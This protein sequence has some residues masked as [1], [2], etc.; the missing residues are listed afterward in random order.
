MQELFGIIEEESKKA[1]AESLEHKQKLWEEELRRGQG[2][3]HGKKKQQTSHPSTSSKAS[4]S[5]SG[6]RVHLEWTGPKPPP[7]PK[8][9]RLK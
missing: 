5:A 1:E 7:P 4:S 3:L 2:R 9:I 8:P 6:D